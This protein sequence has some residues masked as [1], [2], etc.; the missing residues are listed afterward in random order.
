MADRPTL[1]ERFADTAARHPGLAALELGEERLSYTELAEEAA[2]TAAR[3]LAALDGRRPHRVGVL[4]NRSVAAYAGY[5]AANRLGSAAVPLNPGFSAERLATTVALAELDVVLADA[6]TADL[7]VPVVRAD[8][9]LAAD[10]AAS[11]PVH[12]PGPDDIAYIVF[13]SGSTGTPKGV[14]IQHGNVAALLDYAIARYE[15]GPGC[16]LSQ[17]FD[18]TFDPTVWDMFS[19]WGSGATL[20]VPTRNE[21]VRPAR[22]IEHRQITHWFSVPSVITYAERLRDLTPAGMPSLRWSLFGGE[23]LTLEQI[24]IWRAAAPQSVLENLYGPTEVTVACTQYRLPT[25]PEDWP[26]SANGTVPIGTPYPHLDFLV[27]DEDGRPADEGELCVRGSQRFPG[28]LRPA[29]NSGRF[30]S[31]ADGRAV[32]HEAGGP[33]GPELYYRTGD[34]VSRVGDALVHLGRLDQQVKV[35]GH[36]IELGEVEAALR[37]LPGVGEAVVLALPDASGEVALE[38]CYTGPGQDPVA[39]RGALGGRLPGYMVP[40]GFTRLDAF[41]LN[42]NGKTDR[43]ALALELAERGQR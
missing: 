34:R 12:L 27:L 31:F 9:P 7:P 4:A 42:P 2:R 13:T 26:S 17:T 18:L 39:L 16:R 32:L 40:R 21:L 14:P 28:Y 38:A 20:V 30:L 43:R 5:L 11:V 24:R 22:F 41:P 15:L 6:P 37:A 19:A 8:A 3:L 10:A 29:D 33:P 36:R 23:Q 1:Y 35:R 25:R